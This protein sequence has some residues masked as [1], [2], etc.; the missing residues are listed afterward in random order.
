MI[1]NTIYKTRL[2]IIWKGWDYVAPSKAEMLLD[3]SVNMISQIVWEQAYA[4]MEHLYKCPM[5]DLEYK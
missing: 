1:S 2:R 4:E 5:Q 3:G